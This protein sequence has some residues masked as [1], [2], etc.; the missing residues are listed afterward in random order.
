MVDF[1]LDFYSGDDV[2]P[3]NMGMLDQLE[4]MKWVQKYI[5]GM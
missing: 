5:S 4:A 2:V 1:V 3:G